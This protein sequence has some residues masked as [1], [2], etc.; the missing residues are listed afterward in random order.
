MAIIAYAVGNMFMTVWGMAAD[1]ILQCFCIDK[2]LNDMK[3]NR[4]CPNQLLD[5]VQSEDVQK[6]IKIATEKRNKEKAKYA[7]ESER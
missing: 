1:A 5:F 7:A 3:I 6:K 4:Y 2:E